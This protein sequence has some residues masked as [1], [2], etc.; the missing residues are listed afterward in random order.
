MN[1][2]TREQLLGSKSAACASDLVKYNQRVAQFI[3]DTFQYWECEFQTWSQSCGENFNFDLEK[4][5]NYTNIGLTKEVENRI[6]ER[7]NKTY[8]Y[9]DL[10]LYFTHHE[11]SYSYWVCLWTALEKPKPWWINVRNY[12]DL[13]KT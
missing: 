1:G 11:G 6:I 5:G 12:F 13:R 8:G 9:L 2:L 3:E 7:I 4:V 10:H